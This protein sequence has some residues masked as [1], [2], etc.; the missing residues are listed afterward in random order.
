MKTNAGLTL[1]Y[2]HNGFEARLAATYHSAFTRDPSWT[3]GQFIING[4]ETNLS[5]NLSQQI[6]KNV[7]IHFGADNLT[8]QK[9]VYTDPNN[10]YIQQIREFGRRYNLG[11][12]YR[13]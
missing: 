9:L 10:A 4:A 6:T 1:W 8:N 2:E 11:F 13:M 12:S 3:A 5:F 7:Q